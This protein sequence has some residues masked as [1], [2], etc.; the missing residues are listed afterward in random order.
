MFIR[1]L[2]WPIPLKPIADIMLP[3]PAEFAECLQQ[4]VPSLEEQSR[5]TFVGVGVD[6]RSVSYPT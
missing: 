2:S 1:P 6:C 5:I 4:S 3:A